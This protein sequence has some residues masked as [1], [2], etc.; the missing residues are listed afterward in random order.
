M[1][2][3]QN[4]VRNVSFSLLAAVAVAGCSL[5]PEEAPKTVRRLF[6][7]PERKPIRDVNASSCAPVIG[8]AG[9]G[10]GAGEDAKWL[11][12]THRKEGAALFRQ[13]GARF[14]RQWSAVDRWQDGAGSHWVFD[15]KLGRRVNRMADRTTDMKNA[16]S[17]YKEY[18][19]KVLL[20]LENYGV[21][22][23]LET[24]AR[25]GD[26]RD[27]TRV[28]CDYV[29]WIVDNGFAETVAGFELG[30]EPYWMGHGMDK[31]G[32]LT[33]EKYAERWCAIIPEIL[34]IMPKAEFGMPLAEYFKADPDIAA[35][36]NRALSTTGIKSE[37]YFDASNLNRWSARFAMAMKPQFKNV[38]HIIYHA[39][40]TDAPFSTSY[41][42][43]QRYRRFTEAFPEL[44]GMDFWIS[45]WRDRSDEDVPSHM[46]YRETLT[47]MGYMLMMLA[48]PDVAGM[49]LHEFRCQTGTLA[50]S[51]PDEKGK[52]G[53]WSVQWMDGAGERPDFDSIGESRVFVGSLGPA[54]Q[55]V[56]ESLRRIPVVLDFGSDNR[57][58]YSEG[59]SNAVYACS[60]YY[61]SVLDYR[62][63]LRQGK[64]GAELPK[65]NGDCSY[66]ITRDA[67]KRMLCFFAV[68]TKSEEV[69]FDLEFPELWVV[70]S[71]EYRVE[72]CEE[73][74]LDA[75]EIAGSRLAKTYAY[76]PYR[77]YPLGKP[78]RITI[79]ANSVT[80]V[81]IPAHRTWKGDG[82]RRLVRETLTLAQEPVARPLHGEDQTADEFYY[83]D[84]FGLLSLRIGAKLSV[85]E[86]GRKSVDETIGSFKDEQD[87]LT[88]ERTGERTHLDKSGVLVTDKVE[89]KLVCDKIDVGAFAALCTRLC[90]FYGLATASAE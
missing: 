79:P 25:S 5:A 69:S 2:G 50:W 30:N 21:C 36:R 43:I 65:I 10:V 66:L 1:S 64:T 84:T 16:F 72:T 9:A 47:K 56:V 18:G 59:C 26:I 17:F 32:A 61:G 6:V 58:A 60:D 41:W 49:N 73:K 45:E 8:F 63:A 75:H 22:T 90:H 70:G 85:Y 67:G 51:F 54:M 39:Y 37:N 83:L 68:N 80:T 14:V 76:S 35:V 7:D 12:E 89:L 86:N 53:N 15:K 48:Q 82:A 13:C 11:F 28:M 44:K 24:G 20:T 74:Y 46:R 34:K 87:V 29:R 40:G 23:N 19:I 38:R 33:P 81:W 78:Y 77:F 71:P 42:G 4:I 57:G 62:F 88:F 3:T 31:E 55:N 27:I 52:T